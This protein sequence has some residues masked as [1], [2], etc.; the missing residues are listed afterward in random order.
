MVVTYAMKWRI[1]FIFLMMLGGGVIKVQAQDTP[2]APPKQNWHF[3]GIFGTYDK[4]QLQRGLQVY[5]Q[6]CSSCHGLKFV[7]F[8][9]LGLLGYSDNDIR[10]FARNHE[11][12]DGFDE[13]G[14]PLTRPAGLAD[15]FPSPFANEKQAALA[16]NGVIPVDLSLVGRARGADYIYALLTGYN[17]PDEGEDVPDGYYDNPYF[18]SGKKIAM[19]PPLDDGMI[20]Y[21][22]GTP[23]TL[24]NYARD[25]AA[26]L[27][28]SGDPHREIRHKT[29]FRVIIFLLIFSLLVYLVKRRIW[30]QHSP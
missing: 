1:S 27:I 12:S 26:F 10:I 18:A 5:N 21:Q 9:D 23:P 16:N 30:S 2:A 19:A 8:R 25:I 17:E 13:T 24:D 3:S 11:V 15:Y 28:W 22:D 29:G 20:A 14:L 6:V 4:A 7:A